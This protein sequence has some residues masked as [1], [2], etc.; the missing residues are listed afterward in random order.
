MSGI[1]SSGRVLTGTAAVAVYLRIKNG[2]RRSVASSN[3]ST[4][5][6]VSALGNNLG[7]KLMPFDAIR[8]IAETAQPSA[9]AGGVHYLNYRIVMTQIDNDMVDSDVVQEM[10]GWQTEIINLA[11]NQ[12]SFQSLFEE[13][14]EENS[15]Q[16][17]VTRLLVMDTLSINVE[18]TDIDGDKQSNVGFLTAHLVSS[19]NTAPTAANQIASSSSPT[20]SIG[21]DEDAE[22]GLSNDIEKGRFIKLRVWDSHLW[23]TTLNKTDEEKAAELTPT[24]ITLDPMF[25][26]DASSNYTDLGESDDSGDVRDL[27][28]N[29]NT[30]GDERIAGYKQFYDGLI[31][32]GTHQE[33]GWIS[34]ESDI[35][36]ENLNAFTQYPL[37]RE[38]TP[39]YRN[40]RGGQL[41]FKGSPVGIGQFNVKTLAVAEWANLMG[42]GNSKDVE[43][44]TIA[45]DL[46]DLRDYHVSIKG[47]NLTCEK[48]D[49]GNY[50][51]S[52]GLISGENLITPGMRA[53]QSTADFNVLPT[54][55]SVGIASVLTGEAPINTFVSN[56][57]SEQALPI[58]SLSNPVYTE[59]LKISG[60]ASIGMSGSSLIVRTAG[61]T[62]YEI[63]GNVI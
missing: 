32:G 38:T 9:N 1:D 35:E 23:N 44:M 26:M 3:S 62:I 34:T 43:G 22:A 48:G 12:D 46:S 17:G 2:T 54:I 60:N 8:E 55:E 27:K 40:R 18:G 28:L 21:M 53:G 19:K 58:N 33:V 14:Y 6:P 30:F 5:V 59:D 45:Q 36:Y 20:V 56:K 39:P 57:I 61:G 7:V 51:G 52:G 47:L 25:Y 13:V 41:Q 29:V 42:D 50:D 11:D 15:V 31:V 10:G 16:G 37:Y 24:V 63:T 4:S 49:A